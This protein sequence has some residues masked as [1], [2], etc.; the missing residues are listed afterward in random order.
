MTTDKWLE[1]NG[2]KLDLLLTAAL[3]ALPLI[4]IYQIVSL[5][6]PQWD[7]TVRYLEGRTLAD[8]L[9]GNKSIQAA[10]AGEFSNNLLFYFE[11][12]REPLSI[13]IFAVTSFLFG[14]N[15]MP[16]IIIVYLG[17]LFAV[18]EL[19]KELKIDRLAALSVFANSYA[20]FFFFVPNG[21]EGLAIAFA[22]LGVVYLLRKDPLSG[23]FF[24]LAGIAK[25]PAMVLFPLVLLLGGGKK[26]A[27][28]AIL[29]AAPAALWGLFDYAVYGVPFYSYIQSAYASLVA[30]GGAGVDAYALSQVLAYPIAFGAIGFLL[31]AIGER[32]IKFAFGST[33]KVLAAGILAAAIGYMLIVPHNDQTTQARYGFLLHGM[34]LIPSA[35][36]LSNALRENKGLKYVIAASVALLLIYLA[37]AAYYSSTAPGVAYYN[38]GSPES[39]YVHADNAVNKTGFGGCKYISNAWVPMIY[40]GFDVYSPFLMYNTYVAIPRIESILDR[41]GFRNIPQTVNGILYAYG[42]YSGVNYTQLLNQEKQYP[43]VF[44]KSIGVAKSEILSLNGSTI[45]YDDRDLTV[46]L[47]Q[48]ASCYRNAI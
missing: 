30:N 21:G 43:V 45:A 12:Y 31:G 6:G 27:K 16:Y 48:N 15:V 41:L 46:Y 13:P 2:K 28:A 38:A 8:F 39:I 11:P 44:F 10:F 32:K 7:L 20:I 3:A 24:G 18:S 23:L 1:K 22:I 37:F 14:K 5:S 34:L 29:E 36:M 42:S 40:A 47:P 17:Y 33:A 35:L 19:C 9:T 26:I 4:I 25:Y